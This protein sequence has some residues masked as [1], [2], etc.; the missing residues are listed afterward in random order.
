M[1]HRLLRQAGLSTLH[2]QGTRWE[3]EN[4]K[5]SR[6]DP[7][8]PYFD[9]LHQV[10]RELKSDMTVAAILQQH[11]A[12]PDNTR[13][14]CSIVRMVEGYDAADPRRASVLALREEW[15]ADGRSAQVRIA[16]GYGS[17]V[18]F[19]ASECRRNGVTTRL[20]SAVTA[21]EAG[22]GGALIRCAN[23][24]ANEC[25]AV[26]L[27]VPIPLLREIA[28]PPPERE[29]TAAAAQMASATS[30]KSC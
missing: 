19:L 28:L 12:G 27:T 16:G 11:F 15:M 30:S 6:G 1:T 29:K 5:F 4:G 22:D 26:V 2:L 14:R 10:L 3:V 13:L 8:D 25:D 18:N 21:I 23:G 20:G 9:R 24:D 7:P 17:L